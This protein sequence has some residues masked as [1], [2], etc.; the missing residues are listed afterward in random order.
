MILWITFFVLML[1]VLATPPVYP[2][3]RRWGFAP[4]GFA[5]LFLVIVMA[6][7]LMGFF[8]RWGVA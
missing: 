5:V 6:L 2:Y 8:G 7:W 4:F 1:V 3:S